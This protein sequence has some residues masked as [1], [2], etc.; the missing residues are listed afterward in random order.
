[1]EQA[2]SQPPH[3][4]PNFIQAKNEHHETSE[5]TSHNIN[6]LESSPMALDGLSSE[7]TF[8]TSNIKPPKIPH[9]YKMIDDLLSYE[10]PSLIKREDSDTI[11]AG[12]GEGGTWSEPEVHPVQLKQESL[13]PSPLRRFLMKDPTPLRPLEEANILATYGPAKRR[14]LLFDYDGTLTDIVQDPAKAIIPNTL[15]S[16]LNRLASE[17]RNDVWVISGRD[18]NFMIAQLG[19]YSDIGLV[20]EHGAFMRRPGSVVWHDMSARADLTWRRYVKKAFE[21]FISLSPGTCLEEKRVALVLHYRTVAHPNLVAR[22]AATCKLYLE[23]TFNN[24]PVEFVDGKCVLE[25]RPTNL[26]K[27]SVVRKIIREVQDEGKGPPDLVLCVG[28]DITDEGKAAFRSWPSTRIIPADQLP[29]MFLAIHASS[30]PPETLFTV[31][32]GNKTKK[33]HAEF[34]LEDPSQVFATIAMLNTCDQSGDIQGLGLKNPDGSYR[35]SKVLPVPRS[36]ALI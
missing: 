31:T 30:F 26:D 29:D 9:G 35:G 33:S 27:G 16:W 23:R 22:D 14:L 28:D 15:V 5:L 1:M 11:P 21:H 32:I 6:S 18:Q 4:N 25:A 24:W 2:S 34:F 36:Y 17:P 7:L 13:S 19:G 3:E 8:N 10:Q 20:A 12:S